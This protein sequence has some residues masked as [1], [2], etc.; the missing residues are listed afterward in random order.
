MLFKK[1]T[2]ATLLSLALTTAQAATSLDEVAAFS[3]VS[4]QD[5]QNAVSQ[6]TLQQ[7]IIDTM[8]KPYEGKPWWQYRKLFITTSRINE[9]VKF[10]FNHEKT[11]KR[12]F[13]TYGVPPE[14]VCAI[15]GVETFYGRNM[16]TWKVL[17]ALYTLGFHYPPRESYFSKEFGQFVKLSL[18]EG[19][20]LKSIKG[21][22]AGAMGMGQFMPTSYLN[23]AVDFDGDGHI[24]LFTSTEDAIGSVA[25]YF[26]EHGFQG[27]FGI[28]YPA[29]AK[30]DVSSLI[31]KEWD[32]TARELY[33][34]GVST[35]VNLDPNEKVRLFSYDLED[36]SK[37]LAVGLN[38]FNA[39]MRYNKSPLYARAV[40]ELAE[41]IRQEH[42]K[43]LIKQG[44]VVNPQGRR[45]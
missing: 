18:Q 32:L 26:K 45:P 39:I 16:G 38:N 4:V 28:L 5:L 3:K 42:H 30:G 31:E 40:Y 35:K 33:Q 13:E 7:K 29:K 36:G 8:Q 22:Y 23:F 14:I 25:N 41:F 9:G 44:V 10:Y 21:S 24:N 20:D 11:L 37:D 27:G 6:A 43:V 12:A 1:F 19:W 15:I 17:D 34:G 2:L